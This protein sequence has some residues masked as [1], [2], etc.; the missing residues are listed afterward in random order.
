MA[1]ETIRQGYAVLSRASHRQAIQACR[2]GRRPAANIGGSLSNPSADAMRTLSPAWV[3][4][5]LKKVP[6]SCTV[7][8]QKFAKRHPYSILWLHRHQEG[9][10][11]VVR[12]AGRCGATSDGKRQGSRTTGEGSEHNTAAECGRVGSLGG[13]V[14]RP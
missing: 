5:R 8:G 3:R 4:R 7:L 1:D 6:C 13:G 11:N 12:Y 14:A 9:R 2:V 10:G